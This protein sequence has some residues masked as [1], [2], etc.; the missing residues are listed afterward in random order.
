[1]PPFIYLL[2]L[3]YRVGTHFVIYAQ[4][5]KSFSFTEAPRAAN[6]IWT[7]RHSFVIRHTSRTEQVKKS[8][9]DK[10]ADNVGL[11]FFFVILRMPSFAFSINHD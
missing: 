9:T 7:R 6:T 1:M 10:M 3:L 8:V 4:Q 2:L 5:D 11:S